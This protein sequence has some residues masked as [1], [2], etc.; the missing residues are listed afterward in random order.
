MPCVKIL[1]YENKDNNLNTNYYEDKNFECA[2]ELTTKDFSHE[3]LINLLQNGN[4][5]EKQ[6]AALS[7]D[8]VNNEFE[9]NVLEDNLTGCDGKIREAVALK[10]NRILTKEGFDSPLYNFSNPEIF[11]DATIDINGNICRL[12]IDSV[13]ILKSNKN[14]KEAYLKKI[15]SF[16]EETFVELD[17]F[18]YKDKKYVINKQLFKLYWC[19]ESLKLFVEDIPDEVLYKIVSRTSKEREYTIREK[20]AEILV[21]LNSDKYTE[22]KNSLKSDENYY[23]RVVFK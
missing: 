18:I 5:P 20:T 19:L 23:V 8:T 6:F 1:Q 7:L 11:A 2:C 14:F 12:V 17:K 9:A 13:K 16:T 3:D 22:I 10:I 21:L 4:I 15:I